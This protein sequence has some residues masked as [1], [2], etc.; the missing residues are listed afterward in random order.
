MNYEKVYNQLIER[1][2]KRNKV[3]GYSEKHHIIPK[4]MGGSND[5]SNIVKLTARE[6][7][8][9][10]WL[11]ARQYPNNKRLLNAFSIM[12]LVNSDVQSRYITSSR[13]I[14][15][16]KEAAS[17]S[18][19]GIVSHRRGKKL[20]E[21]H[22]SR[23]SKAM[24]GDKNPAKRPEVREKNRLSHIGKPQ[25]EESNKKRSNALK[26]KKRPLEVVEKIKKGLKGRQL[27]SEHLQALKGPRTPYG[28]QII[29]KCN[30][31]GKEGGTNSITR[32]HNNNCKYKGTS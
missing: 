1:A 5:T 31:C 20:T 18:K 15:E 14:A 25:S 12:S 22:K 13:I 11:L 7:F 6:H 3:E 24:T 4:C 26:G 32:W 21:E 17:V 19:K 16:A 27:S 29:S 9:C 2:Q 28:K 8:I 23:I 10:H 30:Y